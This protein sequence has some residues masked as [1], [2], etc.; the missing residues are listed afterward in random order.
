ME[1]NKLHYHMKILGVSKRRSFDSRAWRVDAPCG[2]DKGR[3]RG[4]SVHGNGV[5]PK[6]GVL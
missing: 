1:E 2:R 5:F 6:D 3:S 4:L